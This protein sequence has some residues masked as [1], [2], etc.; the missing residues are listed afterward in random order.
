MSLILAPLV[1]A[2]I[3]GI[4][5]GWFKP[6]AVRIG[7]VDKPGLKK[8][9]KGHIPVVGGI[10]IFAGF[11]FSLLL[12]HTYP[13]RDLRALIAGSLLLLIIG[14]IDDVLRLPVLTRFMAQIAAALMM[15]LWT[16]VVL[17]SLGELMV[18]GQAVTLGILAIPFTVFAV[19]G[20][21]NAANM[22]DGIDGLLGTLSFF[23]IA[24]LSIAAFVAG[25]TSELSLLLIM[26]GCMVGYLAF[27]M[28][29]PW[30]DRASV[31]MGDGGTMFIGFV[32][33]YFMIKLSQGANPAITP[34]TA[35]W[36]IA[37]PLFDAVGMMIRRIMKGRSPFDGDLEHMHHVLLW[38]GFTVPQSVSIM[39][40]LAATCVAVGL[41]GMYL[42]VPQ[43]LMFAFFLMTGFAHFGLTMRSW[44]LL[45]F[46]NRSICR[47]RAANDRRSPAD[48]RQTPAG[49]D[50]W[51]W[52]ERRDGVDRRYN[53][54][55][56]NLP[57][58]L[59]TGGDD[60]QKQASG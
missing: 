13:L 22:S 6:A 11:T 52:A 40:V 17:L 54:R 32:L 12:L 47:R 10:A 45:K 7:L 20:V 8:R 46:F 30:R 24:G 31:F 56:D 9:H 42:N 2:L 5:I 37:L 59:E 29:T 28:R 49:A 27:N 4:L 18:P 43:P 41:G 38:A 57:E 58:Q 34:V 25:R 48:R 19:V 33:A 44:K 55:R 36:L 51:P 39:G 53:S 3:T 1:A 60:N 23:A 16:G 35:L 21:I 50:A 26:A 14:V 15:A